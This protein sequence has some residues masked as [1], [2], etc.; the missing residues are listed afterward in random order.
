MKSAKPDFEANFT[1]TSHV[2]W[3]GWLGAARPDYF[4]CQ[5]KMLTNALM[6]L[7]GEAQM[8]KMNSKAPAGI[9]SRNDECYSMWDSFES[10]TKGLNVPLWS[11]EMV[12]E[13]DQRGREPDTNPNAISQSGTLN[14]YSE[15]TLLA[16]YCRL[17]SW[18][19]M[20]SRCQRWKSSR[21]NLCCAF[22]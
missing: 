14:G 22:L 16:S 6:S 10:E 5:T 3:D 9:W 21:D 18:S 7:Y 19:Q 8:R 17:K 13:T 4:F 1:T 2:T 20:C 11:Q 15:S 12:P